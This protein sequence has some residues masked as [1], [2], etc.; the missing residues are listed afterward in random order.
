MKRNPDASHTITAAAR[1]DELE[2][3][4]SLFDATMIIVGNIIGIGIFTTT[5]FI[6][7]ALPDAGMIISVWVIGGLLTLC[8]ALTYAELGAALPRA[9]GEYAYLREA[10]GPLCGFLNGWTYFFVINPGSIAAMAIGVI[11]YLG[12]FWPGISLERPLIRA[13][14]TGRVFDLSTGELVAIAL[15]VGFSAI[16]YCGVR[17]GSL[18]QNLLTVS[19]L[20]S[21]LAIASLGL[22][23]GEGS[24][25]H[26]S[27]AHVLASRVDFLGHL[28]TAMIAVIFAFTGW[29]AST[30]V[31]SEIKEPQRN[32]PYSIICGTLIVTI[33]YLL[34]NIAYIYALPVG[35]IKGVVN[36][37]ETAAVALFGR[38]AS[39]YVSLA[40]IISVL[41][42]INS[43]ILTAPRIYYAMARDGL[44]FNAAAKVHPKFKSPANSILI[45]GIW[46][47]LLILSGTFGQLLTYTVVAMLTFS[48]LTGVAIFVLRRAKPDLPRPYKTHGFPWVPVVFVLSYLLILANTLVSRP[49]EGLIGLG[50]VGIGI[51]IYFCWRRKLPLET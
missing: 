22:I 21:V 9:G 39:A 33:I 36:I 24:W 42:A 18:V 43:V 41:G 44:F 4:L 12:S 40:I 30:Y 10:Y 50:I 17:T 31:A 27:S 37:G 2:R 34:I 5:G 20:G 15:V 48:I 28:S 23:I 47:S 45:Q 51:P 26:F 25:E 3:R 19:K 8:G 38:Y 49:K 32:V 11:Y 13:S 16:N 6:A 7:D 29:F 14:L 46:S 35:H 1:T